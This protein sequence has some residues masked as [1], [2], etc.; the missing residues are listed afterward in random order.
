ML[1]FARYS[2]QLTEPSSSLPHSKQPT[3]DPYPKLTKFKPH[4]PIPQFS[5]P[6]NTV[7]S[8]AKVFQLGS[9]GSPYPSGVHISLLSCACYI[10]FDF[11]WNI[12]S[13]RV[14]L[15]PE[16]EGEMQKHACVRT[17]ARAHTHTHTHTD[18]TSLQI[19]CF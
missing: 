3:I 8:R 13:T 10:P 4:S 19:S 16:K 12:I 11:G 17:R 1:N 18:M 9:L 7:P 14:L 2:K 15:A 6:F 5:Y